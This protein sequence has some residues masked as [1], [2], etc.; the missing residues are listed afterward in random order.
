MAYTIGIV[1]AGGKSNRFGSDKALAV[2]DELQLIEY[3]IRVLQPLCEQ[4][5]ISANSNNYKHLGYNVV[6]DNYIDAGPLAGLEACMKSF[7][8]ENYLV[9]SCDIPLINSSIY[10]KMLES[11]KGVQAA[12][13]CNKNGQAEPLIAV[14]AADVYQ[15]IKDHLEKGIYKANLILGK[16][17]CNYVPVDEEILLRNINTREQLEQI[18]ETKHKA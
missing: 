18:R 14:Y 2:F 1:L 6:K 11:M 15:T 9:A 7:P 12:V 4:I 3:S 5:V 13:A 8:S 10:R 17:S 16:I